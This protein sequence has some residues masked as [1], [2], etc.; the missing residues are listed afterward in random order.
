VLGSSVPGIGWSRKGAG[1]TLAM[2]TASKEARAGVKGSQPRAGERE[3]F[4]AFERDSSKVECTLVHAG[5]VPFAGSRTN[6]DLGGSFERVGFRPRA[7][8]GSRQ[9]VHEQGVEEGTAC[10]KSASGLRSKP[11][12]LRVTVLRKEARRGHTPSKG[13]AIAHFSR[14]RFAL[15]RG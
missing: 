9:W 8:I 1:S 6:V 7:R 5:A 4:R 13:D 12:G 15:A 10:A 14:C 3:R 11:L 2:A